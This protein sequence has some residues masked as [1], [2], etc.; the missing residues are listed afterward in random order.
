MTRFMS[1][2]RAEQM[3]LDLV[4]HDV[5][6]KVELTLLWKGEPVKNR[7]VFIRGPERF[8]QNMKTDERGRVVFSPESPGQYTFRS[9]KEEMESGEESGERVQIDSSQHHNGFEATFRWLTVID[10]FCFLP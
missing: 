4:P 6:N 3:D 7:M 9:S 5:G 1:L 8:R 10:G 2:G